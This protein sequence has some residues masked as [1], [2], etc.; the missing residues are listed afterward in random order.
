LLL[1]L[2]ALSLPPPL[3]TTLLPPPLLAMP[4]SHPPRRTLKTQ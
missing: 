1:R 4:V 2:A 3:V